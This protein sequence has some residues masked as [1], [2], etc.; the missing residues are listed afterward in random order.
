MKP[1]ELFGV[2]VRVMGLGSILVG[3]YQIL[4]AMVT[5]MLTS[6][7]ANTFFSVIIYAGIFIGI[8]FVLMKYAPAIERFF[9]PESE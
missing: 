8:G 7:S 2:A 1:K 3:I 9:Y 6:T 4:L 5:M